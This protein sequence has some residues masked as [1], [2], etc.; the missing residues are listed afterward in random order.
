[1]LAPVLLACAGFEPEPVEQFKL[2]Q[3][4]DT[5]SEND[6]RVS[7][8]VLKREEAARIFGVNLHK[9]AVQPVWLEIENRSS[10][11]FWLMLHGL[12]PNYYSA[13]E[14]AYMNHRF[15][16]KKA[17][18]AMD[19]HFSGLG[20]Q[21]RIGPGQT[22]SGFAF[23]N[24]TVGTKE[25]RVQLYAPGDVRNFDFF[26]TVPGLKSEWELTDFESLYAPGEFIHT[27]TEEQ[28]HTALMNLA[29]CTSRADGSG[30]GAPLNGVFI[31]GAAT[32][33]A[34]VK[35]GWDETAFKFD[36]TALFGTAYFAGR[37]PDVQ[38]SKTR[39]RV[40]ST[41]LVRLWLS[42]VLHR[43]K[44]VWIASV[45]RS[46]DPNVDESL[47]YLAEE[48]LL[49]RSIHRWGYVPGVGEVSKENP[50][51]TF[52]DSPYW[53]RGNRLVLELVD[54][55]IEMDEVQLFGWDW[56]GRRT[57]TR[58]EFSHEEAQ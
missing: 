43:G 46:I 18:R 36:M 19:R 50:R 32:L 45:S 24:E 9:H 8:A 20:I 37:L 10:Q 48:L 11:T 54:E 34:L 15:M 35:A 25:V 14:V 42:P 41:N 22:V 21:Q 56:P 55:R 13:H 5:K 58:A 30:Q 52:A 49:A 40:D 23:S 31:N 57:R 47:V 3:R 16:Q 44:G 4:A 28:L 26:V 29:C 17:N 27:E 33:R 39:R 53:T 2:P 1:L 12:D 51:N 7:A 6:L 38:F